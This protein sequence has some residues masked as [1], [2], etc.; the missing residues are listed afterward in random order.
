MIGPGKVID[1]KA[2]GVDYSNYG[3][4]IDKYPVDSRRL[5][6]RNLSQRGR[7]AARLH[8]HA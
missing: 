3:A 7:S 5:R 6:R 1:L 4:P 8:K 2:Q